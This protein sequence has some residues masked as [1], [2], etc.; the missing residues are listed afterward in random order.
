M[1][2]QPVQRQTVQPAVERDTASQRP[3][4]QR[5][6]WCPYGN[7][8]LRNP[9]GTIN[10]YVQPH[11]V[12][13]GGGNVPN[14][15]HFTLP[16]N[17]LIPFP[18]FPALEQRPS[19]DL[20]DS[21]GR[22]LL[23]DSV[24]TIT[25]K[26]AAEG[27]L[28]RYS[29]W[30]FTI[31]NSLQGVDQ[32]TAF[33]IFSVVQP[34]DYPLSQLVNEL[35]FGAR[36]RIDATEPITFAGIEGYSVEP[37][38]S[39]LERDI[40]EKLASEMENGAQIAFDLATETLDSTETSMTTRFAGGQGKTGG[41]PLDRRLSRELERDLPRMVG[42]AKPVVDNSVLEKKVDLLVDHAANQQAK[43]RIRE[44]E[45]E[46]ARLRSPQIDGETMKETVLTGTTGTPTRTSLYSDGGEMK[47]MHSAGSGTLPLEPIPNG[48]AVL[49]EG[50]P[51][52][53][54]AKPFGKYTVETPDGV[55]S[56]YEREEIELAPPENK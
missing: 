9:D 18:T 14:P 54:V 48:A 15:Y 11:E 47:T 40:A 3:T 44:L 30:G 35:S 10:L 37:L 33:R 56:T 42:T 45:E 8:D 13:A 46:N 32:D 55:R 53:V 25:A 5:Y 6:G 34:L 2:A 51:G 27:V 28:Q 1:T 12:D 21:N 38:R 31:L 7:I 20:K 50:V 26:E 49:V 29:G 4:E 17:Q 39:D 52:K 16:K 23:V 36:E 19:D 41:D 22:A 43:D 24:R